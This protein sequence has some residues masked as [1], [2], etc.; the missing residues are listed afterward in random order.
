MKIFL[1][2]VFL[3]AL[4][5]SLSFL[6]EKDISIS[7]QISTFIQKLLTAIMATK[8]VGPHHVSDDDC[9]W[10]LVLALSSLAGKAK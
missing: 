8:K 7:T 6:D 4:F 3:P 5:I 1:L 10:G 9:D 2:D